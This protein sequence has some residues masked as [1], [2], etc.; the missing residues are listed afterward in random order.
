MNKS[1][2]QGS[3]SGP[4]LF[5]IFINDLHTDPASNSSL[6]K[7]ADDSTLIFPFWKEGDSNTAI[8]VVKNFINGQSII[9]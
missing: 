5:N 8:H 3:A 2:T 6:F 4:Y 7:D 1:S 9:A